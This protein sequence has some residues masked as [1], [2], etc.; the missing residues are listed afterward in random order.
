MTFAF[1]AAF[2][3]RFPAFVDQAAA[4]WTPAPDDLPGITA[5]IAAL[6]TNWDLRPLLRGIAC[7]TLVVAG[8][9]DPV[10]PLAASR[11]L[12]EAIPGARLR[13]VPGA[14]HSVLAEGGPQLLREV[15]D[16][17]AAEGA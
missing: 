5:Q 2:T 11:E 17:L 6:R 10:V 8:E 7:P 16:F 4:L 15:S 12:A 13:V 9:V 14:A 1:G 3:D